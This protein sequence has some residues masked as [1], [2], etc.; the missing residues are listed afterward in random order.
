MK[1]IDFVDLKYNPK[2]TDLICEFY[3]EKDSKSNLSY[4]QLAGGVAAES[5]IGTW[6]ELTT[7]KSYMKKLAAKVFSIKRN[8]IKIAYPIE[9]FELDNIPNIISSIAGN[10]FGLKDIKNLR[11]EDVNFP[12]AM[13]KKYR[14]PLYGISGIR[15][16]LKVYNRPLLGTIIKPKLGLNTQDHAK[17]AYDAWLG[18]CDIVKDDENLSSQNFNKFEE[19]LK[20]T[21]K[22]KEKAEKKTG[23][24]KVYMVN[25]TAETEEMKRRMKLVSNIGNE[26]AMFDII[27][28]GWAGLQTVR[29]YNQNLKL[30]MHA[31]RAGHAAF[32]KGKNG[33]SMKVIAKLS[34]LI[35]FDQ[36]H[37]G[38]IF[39]KMGET[40]DEV[41]GN[42]KACKE[43]LK[44]FKPVFPVCS[45]GLHPAHVE[46]LVNILGKDIIIQ[47]GGGIHG[48]PNGTIEGARAARQAIEA[49][50]KKISLEDYAKSHKQLRL[51][52]AKWK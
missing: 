29:N 37:V 2:P 36:L 48:H 9:L 33:I 28:I 20:E 52:L 5:S 12:N 18:G 38:T 10:I 13:L 14:G 6:T 23:E 46:K 30:V 15:K 35:G 25:V 40:K 17:V 3:L 31:H 21:F 47:M 43:E 41:L 11:F 49:V 26:Y 51:A 42:V 8:Y 19:R 45:G 50:M 24:K 1:Y 7:E 27:T 34:R 22:M 4:Q 16:L 39:G 44:N 32:T